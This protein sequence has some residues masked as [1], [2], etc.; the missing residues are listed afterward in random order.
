GGGG[1]ISGCATAAKGVR[2][3]IRIFGVETAGA[4]DVKQSLERGERVTIPP[5]TTIADGIRTQAPGVLTFPVIQ[6]FVE[7]VL[8]VSDEDVLAAVRLLLLRLK[9]VVEPTGAVPLAAVLRGKLPPDCRRVG[10][11][12]SGG[13]LDPDLIARLWA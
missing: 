12:L 2:P 5:P 11:I 8:I 7:D 4:D 6:R 9:I 1:L 10:V 3:E 13:N